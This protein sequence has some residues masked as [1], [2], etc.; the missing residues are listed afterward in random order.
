MSSLAVGY[1]LHALYVNKTKVSIISFICH[2]CVTSCVV[3]IR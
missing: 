2:C 1:D 3:V